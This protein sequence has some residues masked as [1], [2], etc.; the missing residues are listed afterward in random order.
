METENKCTVVIT[1]TFKE[2][3]KETPEFKE[4]SER[5]N[6]NGEA[7]GGVVVAKHMVE[8][9]LGDGEA[10]PHLVLIVEYPSKEKAIETFTNQE[11][12]S[13]VPLRQVA[14]KEVNILITK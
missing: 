6:A 7:H 13:I 10:L 9:N 11:Y 8:Q 3:G 4:Y 5:S 14:L 2:G 12:L 1:A